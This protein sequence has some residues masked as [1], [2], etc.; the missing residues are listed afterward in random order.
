MGQ[1]RPLAVYFRSFHVTNIAQIKDNSLNGVLG[2]RTQG[3]R[4]VGT[5]ESTELW[6]HTLKLELIFDIV[7]VKIGAKRGC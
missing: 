6:R 3:D 2:T 4:M 5:D 1:S 7:I